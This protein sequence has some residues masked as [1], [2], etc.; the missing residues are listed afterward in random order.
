MGVSKM[1]EESE[2]PS[3]PSTTSLEENSEQ[4]KNK[5][6]AEEKVEQV[7]ETSLQPSSILEED[8]EQKK[9]YTSDEAN[10]P[11]MNVISKELDSNTD[12]KKS[13]S[14]SN[15]N[16]CPLDTGSSLPKLPD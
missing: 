4:A 13:I 15:D 7:T 3:L 12:E 11:S 8:T 16:L 10:I 9:E 2:S 1:T 5:L 14:D 6:E